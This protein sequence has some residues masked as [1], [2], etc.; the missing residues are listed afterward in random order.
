MTHSFSFFAESYE[1]ER[2]KTLSV[3]SEFRDDELGFRPA[4]L[5]RTPLELVYR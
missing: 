4:P 2:L 5:A 1:T 3:W